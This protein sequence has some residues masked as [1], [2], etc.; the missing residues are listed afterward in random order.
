V[1]WVAE[2]SPAGTAGVRAGD[3]LTRVNTTAI[4]AQFAEQLPPVNQSLLSLP[5]GKPATLVGAPWRRRL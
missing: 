2:N 5:I 3:V 1:S 4:D